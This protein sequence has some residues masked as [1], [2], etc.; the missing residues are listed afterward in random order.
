[1]AQE[2]IVQKNVPAEMRDGTTL[3]A[4][5]YRPGGEASDGRYP[6]L[7]TRQPYGKE[8]PTVTSYLNA[9]KSA[10]RGYIVVIQDVRG[11]FDSG[12]EWNPSV[13][14]FEDGYDTVEWAA[15]LPG[16]NGDVGM[17][18][19]SYFGM[20]QWQA[21]VMQPPSLKS[22]APGI[23]W[24]NYLNGAQ[25]RGGVRELGLR[26]YWWESV[27]ALD[28]LFRRYHKD[29]EKLAELLPAHVDVIDNLP[30]EYG[31]LPLKDLPDPGGVLPHMFEALDLG[32]ADDV[33]KYLNIDGRYGDVDVPTFH[34]GCWYDVFLG[35]TLRQ[36]EAMKELAAEGGSMPPRLL[37][38]PW[39]HTTTFPSMVGDLDFGL[40]SSGQFLNCRG[41]MT[42]YHLRWFDA[43]LK[44]DE[45]SL[46]GEP[47]IEVFVMGENRWRGYEEWPVPGSREE[48]WYLRAHGVL[49]R[50]APAGDTD[51]TTDEYDYDPKD[52]VPTVGGALLMPGVYRAGARDQRS[53][54]D[55][56][57][58]LVYTSEE[59]AVDYTAIGA[60]YATLYA[61]SSAPDTDFV[62]RLVDVYPDGRA[63]GVTDG[64]IRASARDS[65]PAPGAIEPVEPSPIVPDEV[66]EYVIDLWATGITFEAG[67]RLRVEITSSSFPRWD[68][69]LNTGEDTRDSARS[70]VAR[71]RIFHDPDRP[72]SITLTVVDG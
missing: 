38:G 53:I 44:G 39:T 20:T 41:D 69:N 58:V 19:A 31:I 6:V 72:S 14:E 22:I 48:K 1:M 71:Q 68:R 32:I 60:V 56:P 50:E 28:S 70:E 57:D 54:E 43:T 65:Y 29:R 11:R 52:P 35:E 4:D 36:Y 3:V 8:L 25:F 15:E 2:I 59:L 16:S 63:I 47:P 37:V 26:I 40:A 13:H 5:V 10:G 64:I 62:A 55:R 12:G 30:E 9:T 17:Y 42:D 7:L 66:Y 18:G 24:G 34:I 46:A 27:L 45:G 51:G 23:T 61:A 49:S 33:W 67:H 21:A